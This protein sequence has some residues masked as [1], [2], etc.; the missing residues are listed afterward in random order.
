MEWTKGKMDGYRPGDLRR[1]FL[2]LPDETLAHDVT[3]LIRVLAGRC[4][5]TVVPQNQLPEEYSPEEALITLAFEEGMLEAHF[6][7]GRGQKAMQT[8]L[9][10]G[11]EGDE[12]QQK[13][14]R[15]WAYKQT[16]YRVMRPFFATQTPWGSL[17]G[18]RPTKLF[19]QEMNRYG[20]EAA[21][22]MFSRQFDV[23]GE[24]IALLEQITAQ[25]A[26]LLASI[27]PNDFDLYIGIPFCQTRCAYCSFAASALEKEG[28]PVKRIQAFVEPYLD[29]LCTEIE[30]NGRALLTMGNRLRSVYIGGGTPTALSCAQL[31]RVIETTLRTLG[32]FGREFTVEAG[33]P[34][35]ID[36]EK[37]RM[38]RAMGV[39][40]ISINPQTMNDATLRRIGRNHSAA[41]IVAA[42]ELARKQGFNH[43][44][45]DLIVGLEGETA[46]DVRH[47]LDWMERLKPDSL[48]IHALA[49]KRASRLHEELLDQPEAGRRARQM[50][51]EEQAAQMQHDSAATAERM[52]LY[53]YYMYRQ[54]YSAGNLENTGYA[55]DGG[56]SVYNIDIM[57]EQ[58][59]I[60]A[61]GAGAISKWVCGDRL[62]RVANP[63]DIATY[64]QSIQKLTDER[65]ALWQ[66]QH[67][68]PI[69]K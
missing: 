25:Q 56:A 10:I 2:S 28:K 7:S 29:A 4:D 42:Y 17:T 38:L 12:Q 15:R 19:R 37:L 43:I 23:S 30:N 68:L 14:Q 48:T 63:R 5:V 58:V 18:I 65:I 3:E 66:G 32:G 55:R 59:S 64:M 67:A 9:S 8:P 60:L 22:E 21:K 1:V 54:K 11:T 31:E 57:E 50:A 35:S 52:G 20:V 36:E 61:L 34:D 6:E 47:T 40:R 13:R 26:P 46:D 49:L 16:C 45:M 69:E 33:R 62:E 39:T 51:E 24:K 44:N 27:E 41:D 53:P